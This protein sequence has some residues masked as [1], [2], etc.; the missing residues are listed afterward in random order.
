MHVRSYNYIFAYSI[1]W[2][3]RSV[4]KDR[5]EIFGELTSMYVHK[6]AHNENSGRESFANQCNFAINIILHHTDCYIHT[7]IRTI[8]S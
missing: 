2:H 5:G 6:L 4:L 7:D 8:Y 3:V 1:I